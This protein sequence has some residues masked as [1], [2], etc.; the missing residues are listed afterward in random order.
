MPDSID[1]LEAKLNEL[2]KIKIYNAEVKEGA[3]YILDH[4]PAPED[5]KAEEKVR[6]LL[7]R[8][9]T[10]LLQPTISKEAEDDINTILK[11]DKGSAETWVELSECLFR[12]S[13]CREALDALDNALRL[14]P[15]HIQ[16]LCQYSQVQRNRCATEK[17]TVE[18]KR[19]I[20]DDAI[21][22]AKQAIKVDMKSGNAW[23]TLALSL[24]SK[25]TLEGANRDDLRRAYSAMTRAEQNEPNDPDVHFNKGM[26]ESLL[27]HFG[28]A[29]NE[30]AT[31]AQLD[32]FRLKGTRALFEENVTVLRRVNTS[33]QNTH[34]I[35]KR[36]FK[37]LCKNLDQFIKK[38][39]DAHGI[40]S[41]FCII[42]VISE[43]LMMPVVL[44]GVDKSHHFAVLLV[45]QVKAETFKIG[46]IVSAQTP[47]L[48]EE[49]VI[50]RAEAA[51]SYGL[52]EPIETSVPHIFVD[53]QT[54]LVNG[55]SIPDS[56]RA[57]LQV[58]SRVFT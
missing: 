42:N 43:P 11:L 3:Q 49:A 20:F 9:K 55:H 1:D 38:N 26:L 8:C 31:A 29:A 4:L 25:T 13:A 6:L 54:F 30:F 27:G 22:K 53:P 33:I 57:S 40:V 17:L 46:D 41:N 12:R 47:K 52:D 39:G 2:S 23:N 19:A 10:R 48:V 44:L 45:H 58:S 36:E 37:K 16:A 56:F 14:D 18:E 51:P 50:D 28:A 21:A 5:K 15:N 35:G 24:L 32:H 7:L 34:G